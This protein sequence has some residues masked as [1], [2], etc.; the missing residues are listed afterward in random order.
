MQH[1]PKELILNALEGD[2]SAF[3]KIYRATSGFVYSTA[4]R[5]TRNH[6]DA[7]EV[8]QEVFIKVYKN[9]KR[10]RF[11]A[12]FT[13]WLYRIAVNTALNVYRKT[14]RQ[15]QRRADYDT[16]IQTK[17][18]PD[19][20]ETIFDRA[21]AQNRIESLLSTL[22]PE[23]RACIILRE[24]EGLSYREI[25]KVLKININTVRSRL[26]RARQ[27]LLSAAPKE[28]VANEV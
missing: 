23:Q 19:P 24:L 14:S 12:S 20:R 7:E 25:A 4:L 27:A 1:I 18:I 17:G 9:L 5:I 26:K 11:R 3:E 6:A 15:R 13:T 16:A 2:I 10:F 28:V 8:T 22:K 21:D